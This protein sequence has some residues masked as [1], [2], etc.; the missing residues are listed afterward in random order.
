[1]A[2][3]KCTEC[4][5]KISDQASSCPNCGAPITQESV[6]EGKINIEESKSSNKA[7][8]TAISIAAVFII[9]IVIVLSVSGGK[10]NDMDTM[11]YKYGLKALDAT[12]D[13]LDLKISYDEVSDTVNECINEVEKIN[14]ET[15]VAE[16]DFVWADLTNLYLGIQ[17]AQ[18]SSDD[19]Y[20]KVLDARNDLASSLNKKYRS[21]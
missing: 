5:K 12:D 6:I 15:D 19:S 2:L 18:R 21:K 8:L 10:P 3:I 17:L 4:G 1:M 14:S 16:D 11:V 9:L 13:F 20:Q 7:I